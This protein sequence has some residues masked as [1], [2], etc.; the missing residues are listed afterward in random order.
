MK[1]LIPCLLLL[2]AW[3]A[4]AQNFEGTI[5]WSM[6]ME[7]T[8]PATKAKIEEAKKK[9]SD[10]AE[11]AKM[12]KM[13]EQMNDP[14]MKAM[15]DANPAMKAQMENAMK[16]MQSGDMSAMMPKG[17][18]I[19][20]KGGNILTS[21]DGGPMPMDML[22]LKDKDQ[23][24]RIDRTGKTYSAMGGHGGAQNQP[25]PKVTKTS[26]TKKILDYTCTK[27]LVE[28]NEGQRTMQ[29]TIWA[30][31]EIKD[32]D[33]KALARQRM[34]RGQSF[35]MEG[36]D[37]VPLRVEAAS[38]EGNMTMEVTEIKKESLNAGDFTI[39]TDYKETQGMFGGH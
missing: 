14:Q 36:I 27:Y 16:M 32:I 19:K 23:T 29:E 38:H 18:T 25:T 5:K 1:K 4:K 24:Y 7:I 39:P 12:K 6:S 9:M 17:F 15:L 11:Q 34:A 8:D 20:V 31:N 35:M 2:A 26:E 37:G 22:Y 33:L 10:P 21:I 30:T 28:V 3:T 13:Q